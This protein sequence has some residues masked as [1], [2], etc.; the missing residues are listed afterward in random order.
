MANLLFVSSR[1]ESDEKQR[2]WLPAIRKYIE[3]RGIPN[4]STI[5]RLVGCSDQ[6]AVRLTSGAVKYLVNKPQGNFVSDDALRPGTPA[7][8]RFSETP[9]RSEAEAQYHLGSLY[10]LGHN[11]PGDSVI[12]QDFQLARMWLQKAAAKGHSNA[13]NGLGVILSQGHGVAVDHAQAASWYRK[14]AVQGNADAQFN[15]GTK[16]A[17][18]EGVPQD[19]QKAVSW[20]SKAAEQGHPKALLGLGLIYYFGHGRSK[21]YAEAYFWLE[22]AVALASSSDIGEYS[23]WRD[24]AAGNLTGGELARQKSRAASWLSQFQSK[25]H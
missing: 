3:A 14:A 19:Y 17:N 1:P 13:Q 2:L 25:Q 20:L 22:L 4:I 8:E 15:L 12:P 16:Y 18:G 5:C 23:G 6:E 21:N 7:S 9:E 11:L 10:Y 24:A